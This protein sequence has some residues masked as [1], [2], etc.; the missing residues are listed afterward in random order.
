MDACLARLERTVVGDE[1]HYRTIVLMDNENQSVRMVECN[2]D[3]S[4]ETV[5]KTMTISTR[6]TKYITFK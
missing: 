5:Y 2:H 3:S 4:S 6:A 1:R